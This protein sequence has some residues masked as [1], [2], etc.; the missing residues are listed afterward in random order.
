M[1]NKKSL[2][3]EL[4][5]KRVFF[6]NGNIR[7][8]F[9]AKLKTKFGTWTTLRK[10]FN[11]YKSRLE[12]FRNGAI[13][14][15]YETFLNFLPYVNTENYFS[16][17]II[18]KDKNWGRTKGGIVTYS[19]HKYIFE[20][21]RKIGTKNL[22]RKPKYKFEFDMPL[23]S[24]LCEL[25]G[26]FIGDGFT[27][28]Y[29]SMYM[30]QY[31]GNRTLDEPYI[32]KRLKSIIKEISPN[33]NPIISKKDNTIRLTVYSKEF[34]IL[35]TKRFNFKPGKKVYTVTI[36]KEITDSKNQQLIN[37][38]IRGIYDT[39]GSVFYD[40]RKIYKKPYI[41]IHLCS[42]SFGLINQVYD[43]LKKNKLNPRISRSYNKH[44]IQINGV[45]NCKKFI[46]KIGFSNKRHLD[47]IQKI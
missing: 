12:A 34:Y 13:S 19:K 25:I 46:K 1:K 31:T 14:I 23:T 43:I 20:K 22:R 28:K 21:G 5:S 41:R 10:N 40:K 6:I 4:L 38:C 45:E 2:N 44:V 36:P 42:V 16:N 7:N 18:L 35:L 39:D 3:K 17:K 15:P 8:Q 9:F 33:S 26:A 11:I 47:K 27:N 30:I 32:T 29:G 24:K 37:S